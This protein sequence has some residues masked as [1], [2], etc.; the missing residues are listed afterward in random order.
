M[1]HTDKNINHIFSKQIMLELKPRKRLTQI[2]HLL[3]HFDKRDYSL[4][5]FALKFFYLSSNLPNKYVLSVYYCGRHFAR[6]S[7]YVISKINVESKKIK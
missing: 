1:R 5:I 2:Y 3:E 7:K 6:K 4:F